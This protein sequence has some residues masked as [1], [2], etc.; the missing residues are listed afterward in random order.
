MPF[1]NTALVQNWIINNHHRLVPM[2]EL[3]LD[4]NCQD[5][6]EHAM[7]DEYHS[8]AARRAVLESTI[9]ALDNAE[10]GLLATAARL[11]LGK[12]PP[13]TK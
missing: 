1:E 7:A 10:L 13:V 6:L 2:L 8:P 11:E 5:R 9:E 3:H 4:Q 12:L